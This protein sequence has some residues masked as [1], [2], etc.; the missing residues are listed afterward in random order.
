MSD[1]RS[2]LLSGALWIALGR[3]FAN[4]L[5]IISTVILARML[6]P[7]DFG[8]VA[9]CTALMA[10]LLAVSEMP[11]A[12]ALI[13]HDDPQEEHFHTA[14]TMSI[15]RSGLSAL[16]VL[17]LA[18]PVASFYGDDRLQVILWVM[19]GGVAFGG[20]INPKLILFQRELIFRQ[21]F[22]L[23]AGEK[24]AGFI[25]AVTLAILLQ[26]YWALV[27]GTLAT[28]VARV[29]I[30]YRLTPYR[31]RLSLKHA[32]EILSFSIWVTF[33]NWVQAVNWRADPLVFGAVLPTAL[34]GQFSFGQRVT[35][36]II[37]QLAQPVQQTL[38]PA[39]A[40][41]RN[42]PQA[43]RSSYLRAQ[44]IVCLWIYP[45]AFGLVIIA[46]DFVQV[47]LGAQ[48]LQAVPVMQALAFNVA[49]NATCAINPVAMAT[50]ETRALFIRDVRA[51]AIRWPMILAGLYFGAAHG[52]YAMLVGAMIGNAFATVVTTLWAMMLV[53]DITGLRIYDQLSVAVA[54][55]GAVL[56]MAAVEY[57][58]AAGYGVPEDIGA[59]LLR[60]AAL[61]GIAALG[62]VAGI[63][64]MWL[65]RG[66]TAAAE[67]EFLQ[68]AWG[69]IRTRMPGG[70]K[71]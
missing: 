47:V 31:P 29:I 46:A 62:Y 49:I 10:V 9:I 67:T 14:F 16:I 17:A 1:T 61:I 12:Q 15:L 38:F 60:L 8:L 50:G 21:V 23:Q 51:F 35:R 4:T 18:G 68:L 56:V 65:V 71:P 42:N 36:V 26:S 6:V 64:L 48:W 34:L 22:F 37:G 43:L 45:F 27:L 30:S 3:M 33:G 41:S 58:A 5:G 53:R 70:P 28:E 2:R 40:R 24:I 54:P 66:R 55:L 57:A 7:E 59:Q 25:V 32:Q 19:A 11:L 63:A 69:L 13:Q 44:G 52:P 20:F 39:F